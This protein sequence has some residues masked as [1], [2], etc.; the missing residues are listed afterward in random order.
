MGLVLQLNVSYF[1]IA[2]R[3]LLLGVASNCWD[4]WERKGIEYFGKTIFRVLKY[5]L[6]PADPSLTVGLNGVNIKIENL[7]GCMKFDSFL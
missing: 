4:G 3:S 1:S 2:I 7:F 6:S 5:S